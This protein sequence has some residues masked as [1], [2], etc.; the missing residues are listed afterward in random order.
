MWL[1]LGEQEL[2]NL[3]FVYSIAR[4]EENTI[5]IRFHSSEQMRTL[6]FPDVV[7]RDHAFQKIIETMS[8]LGQAIQ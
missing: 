3:D 6:P 4:G 5:E 8:K 7:S 2:V 1:K